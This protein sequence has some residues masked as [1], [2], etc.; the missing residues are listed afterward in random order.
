MSAILE[1][2]DV[3]RSFGGLKVLEGVSMSL[4]PGEIVGLIGPNG[5]GKTTLVNVITAVT[6][7]QG[8]VIRFAGE[9]IEGLT[10]DRIAQR[11]IARTSQIVQPFPRMSVLD[12][13]VAAALFAGGLR[14]VGEARTFAMEQ[15][16]FTGLA[17]VANQSA[18]AL[19]L[20]D[21]KRLELARSLAMRPR[22][23]MLDEVNAGLNAAEIDGALA[24]IAAIA[25]RGVTVLLIEHLMKVV[26]NACSRVAVLHQGRLIAD[27]AP[28]A[29]VADPHVIEAYLGRRYATRAGAAMSVGS[30]A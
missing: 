26:L 6:P 5:A 25:A 4:Q 8:G 14:Q 18:A 11:G 30:T 20:A 7:A 13:V 1:L 22:L 27:G 29:V 17:R 2:Q 16:E 24:L 15:L 3:S 10:P 9:S 28:A 21:R 12:N 23:L 19:S